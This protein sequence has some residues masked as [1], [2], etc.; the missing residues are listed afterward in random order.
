MNFKCLLGHDW[1]GCKCIR[2]GKV[3]DE[4]H[5]WNKDCE[6]CVKCGATRQGAHQWQGCKCSK[7]GK[8]QHQL[9]D[10]KCKICGIDAHD[11]VGCTCRRCG[12]A[13]HDWSDHDLPNDAC[14]RCGLSG[15]DRNKTVSCSKCGGEATFFLTLS[16]KVVVALSLREA[17]MQAYWCDKCQAILCGS[18]VGFPR[19]AAI[20]L[21]T[22]RSV[23]P[24]CGGKPLQAEES[25]LAAID[26][27]KMNNANAPKGL[28]R[29]ALLVVF[30]PTEPSVPQMSAFLM[31]ILPEFQSQHDGT[32]KVGM[33]W[34]KR[35][36]DSIDISSLAVKT[37]G[38]AILDE[39]KYIY[40]TLHL[41][42]DGGEA[43]CFVAYDR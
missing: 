7:C 42:I 18:C 17:L 43:K 31:D 1:V 9:E 28:I 39:S 11:M 2:C 41:K 40:R 8:T 32:G 12:R 4:E 5:D 33:L 37:F 23:C 19:D 6:K 3:R 38:D 36:I 13:F 21:G 16:G 24:V 27:T 35:P 26:K 22:F 14:K 10:C 30:H 15:S 29:Y 34:E 20:G 25:C